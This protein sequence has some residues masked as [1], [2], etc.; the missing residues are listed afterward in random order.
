MRI[1]LTSAIILLFCGTIAWAGPFMSPDAVESAQGFRKVVVTHGLERPWSMAWLPN[2]DV[3]ITERPGRVRLLADGKLRSDPI[4][5]TPEVLVEGQ[6]GL[7]DIA[8]HP[9]FATNRLVYFTLSI[10]T[11]KANRTALARAVFDGRQFSDATMLFQVSQTKPGGQHFGSRLLWLP[12]KTLLMSI[13]DGGNPPVRVQGELARNHAQNFQSHLGKMLHLND[14]GKPATKGA[15]RNGADALPEL[16]SVGHRNIQGLA[17]DPIRKAVWSTEHGALGGDEMNRITPGANYGWP[18][19]TFSKEYLFARTISEHTS[20]P[21][22]TDPDVVWTPA[23]APSGLALYTG[24]AFASWKGDLFAG[25]LKD[26]SIRRIKLDDAGT[27]TG[28]EIIRIGQRVRD[29]R[30][31]P[32]GYLYLLTDESD[33]KLLRL[34]PSAETDPNP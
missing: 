7:L 22:M 18:K 21:G 14:E 10:G 5:G 24:D 4:P 29:V 27:V 26:Q 28:E 6:G 32:D 11:E 12:D 33:G 3:L 16:Y 20:L 25:G 1:S 30:Q 9:D 34:E 2:G 13:G 23:L 17:Y 15:F 19:A 8:L 31:G